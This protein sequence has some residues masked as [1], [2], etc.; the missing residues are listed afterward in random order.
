MSTDREARALVGAAADLTGPEQ[1]VR[2][3]LEHRALS[4][5]YQGLRRTVE[6]HLVGIHETGEALLVAYQTGGGSKSG[7]VP[8]WRTFATDKMEAVEIAD[9]L[10]PSPRPDFNLTAHAMVE[11][12]ARA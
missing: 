8:G 1:A 4:F 7:D 10:F 5:D 11:I 2:A 9:Q 6:P 3:T 12:F